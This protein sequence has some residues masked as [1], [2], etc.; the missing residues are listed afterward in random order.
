MSGEDHQADT[1]EAGKPV[2]RLWRALVGLYV[3]Q[4]VPLYLVA[5]AMPAIFRE[6]GVDLSVIGSLGVLM[7]PWV[8][9]ATW[10][11]WIDRLSARPRIGR[12]GI[13]LVTQ[14]I[15][16]GL[17]VTL[18]QLDPARD[19]G[20]F[21]PVLFA[22]AVASAT[23][24]IATD[25]YAVEHLTP[26][27][28]SRGNAIQSGAVAAGVLI[29]GSFTLILHDLIGWMLSVL[30]VA[31]FAA[32]ALVPFLM[33]PEADGKRATDT[34]SLPSVRQ[35]FRKQGAV[36][37]FF[38]AILFRLPEGLIK[39]LEQS[40]LVDS[41]FSLSQIGLI[42][43]ASAAFV[44]LFG[45]FVGMM[46][47]R[48]FG[49]EVFFAA[50]VLGRS[51]IFALYAI[52]ANSGLPPEAIIWLSLLN[53]FSRYMEIV[54][55]FTAFMRMSSLSQAGT[56]FTLLSSANLLVYMVGSMAAG[57]IAQAMGYGF[58]FWTA[59]TLSLSTGVFSLFLLRTSAAHLQPRTRT[60]ALPQEGVV[61]K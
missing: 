50:L 58:V 34:K 21:F 23:Q 38:F 52:A 1:S 59:T 24:D 12:K 55:L 13:I 56:D 41:G 53:T 9:K 22:M 30:A 31:A 17:I 11:P 8:L 48:R 3:A 4:A 37:I 2:P 60:S 44:G 51:L 42:S 16:F 36:A 45:S 27:H 7:L 43:G 10:A 28:Q 61:L 47:I 33:V 5:A 54:G 14:T 39:S 18:S 46:V 25:G 32:L 20:V 15:V 6:R 40:F 26:A 57:G 35:F 49:L 29:G 19:I